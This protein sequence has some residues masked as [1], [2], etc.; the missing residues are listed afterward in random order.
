M[1]GFRLGF[2]AFLAGRLGFFMVGS[3]RGPVGTGPWFSGP[4]TLL[5]NV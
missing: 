4:R 5:G 3:L 2:A 1:I